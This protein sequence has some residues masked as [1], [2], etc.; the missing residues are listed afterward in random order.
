MWFKWLLVVSALSAFANAQII[1][2]FYEV[3]EDPLEVP[4]SVRAD[5]NDLI[6]YRLPNDTIPTHYEIFVKTDIHNLDYAFN[7][8]VKVHVTAVTEATSI[9]M[10]YRQIDVSNVDL[11]SST[12]ELIQ[13]NVPFVIVTETEFLVITPTTPLEIEQQV[14]A[15]ITYNG[16]LREDN[17]GFYR[18]SYVAADGSTRW[19]ATTKFEPTDARHAFPC[20]DEPEIRSSFSIAIEHGVIYNAIS[21]MPVA[22]RVELA[23]DA[24]RVLTTF[25][26]IPNVQTYLVA[27]VV[28]DFEFIE[29]AL[30]NKPQ[31]VYGTP[32]SIQNGD[33]ELALEAGVKLLEGFE[34]YFGIPYA[35]PK[36]DQIAIP[37]FASGA[38]ENW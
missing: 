22:S 31:K 19:L 26:T 14:I 16:T 35:L 18:S 6:E 3:P 10:H 36:M 1:K 2:K 24:T 38:M 8:V 7:G 23:G 34:R 13:A 9:T 20:Y 4:F 25:E 32:A 12:N 28:S 29:N 17:V 27:Y 5:P 11:W 37:D 21:N 33:G 30:I 15:E